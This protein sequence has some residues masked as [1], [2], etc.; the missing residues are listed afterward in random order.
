MHS[1]KYKLDYNQINNWTNVRAELTRARQLRAIFTAKILSILNTQYVF[2]SCSFSYT[3]DY[4]IGL[5]AT[6]QLNRRGYERLSFV[7]PPVTALNRRRPAGDRRLSCEAAPYQFL[8]DSSVRYASEKSI[9]DDFNLIAWIADLEILQNNYKL[10]KCKFRVLK[11][12][13]LLNVCFFAPNL[14][15]KH[16]NV[17]GVY[18]GSSRMWRLHALFNGS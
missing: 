10:I 1:N 18:Q 7:R 14:W 6:S 2:N 16:L 4:S 11:K 3:S 8:I 12:C 17:N 15:D 9:Y 5:G 13:S